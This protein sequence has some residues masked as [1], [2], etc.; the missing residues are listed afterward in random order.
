MPMYVLRLKSID[1]I[2]NYRAFASRALARSNCG[3]GQNQVLDEGLN[4]AALFEAAST[5]DPRKAT[6]A[7]THGRAALLRIYPQPMTMAQAA[8]WLADLS[9]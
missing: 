9:I 7:A 3:A 1:G 4:E 2:F 6:Q 5:N 8:A